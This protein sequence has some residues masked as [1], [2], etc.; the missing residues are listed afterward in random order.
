[1]NI[2]YLSDGRLRA[3]WRVLLGVVVAVAAHSLAATVAGAARGGTPFASD[4]VYRPLLVVFLLA[5]FSMLLLLADGVKSN[6]V[7]AQGLP[8]ARWLSGLAAGVAVGAAM[9]AAAVAVIAVVG[10]LSLRTVLTWP[11][12]MRFLELAFLLSAAALAEELSFRG[13]PFQRLVEAVGAP[14]AVGALSFLFGLAHLQNPH[15]SRLAMV[16]T[17]LVGAL[18][19]IAY[20]RSRTLWFPW[21]IHWG[22]NAT[23]GLVFGLPVS[24]LNFS[25]V[26]EGTAQGP[27]GLTGGAYGLEASA[28]GTV[29]IL[30]GLWPVWRLAPRPAASNPEGEAANSAMELRSRGGGSDV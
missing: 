27:E 13:Y 2:F 19:A 4:L 15:S 16:N 23:L 30:L 20:L 8:R 28:L 10:E 22:W 14:G 17:V 24:G 6:P 5:G 11:A 7:A 1:L 21:G 3:G 12:T 18:L 26:V 9:V 29:V 25:T